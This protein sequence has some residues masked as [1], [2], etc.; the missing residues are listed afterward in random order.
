MLSDFISLSLIL[1]LT[2]TFLRALCVYIYI[3]FDSQRSDVHKVAKFSSTLP[4]DDLV[5][6][7]QQNA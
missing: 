4:L 5:R 3:I 2:H 6:G 7:G 1:S